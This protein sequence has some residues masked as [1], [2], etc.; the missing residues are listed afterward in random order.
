MNQSR[1]IVKSQ[2]RQRTVI[3]GAMG[4]DRVTFEELAERLDG[5]MSKAT[6]RRGLN[7]LVGASQVV[8]IQVGKG[9]VYESWDVAMGR[10][11]ALN[12][13]GRTLEAPRRAPRRVA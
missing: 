3:L 7:G 11:R 13:T 10:V 9:S 2:A 4:E 1:R 5:Q 6:V 8:A 12:R